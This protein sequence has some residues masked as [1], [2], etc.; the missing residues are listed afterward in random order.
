MSCIDFA[1]YLVNIH[2][3]ISACHPCNVQTECVSRERMVGV[4]IYWILFFEI[5]EVLVVRLVILKSVRSNN[6]FVKWL[7]IKYSF[8][9]VTQTDDRALR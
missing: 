1:K 7:P 8:T 2:V 4:L 6:Q 3:T 5:M 9:C